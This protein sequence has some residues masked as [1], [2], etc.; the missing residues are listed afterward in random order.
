[1]TTPECWRGEDSEKHCGLKKQR[2]KIEFSECD[3]KMPV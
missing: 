2:G 3:K 1:M